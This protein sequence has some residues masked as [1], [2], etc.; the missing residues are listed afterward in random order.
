MSELDTALE[1]LRDELTA[2]IPLPDVEHVTG[3]A[4]TRRRLQ[5][6]AIATVIMVAAAVP[7]LRALPGSPVATPPVQPRTGYVM[8]FAD[9]DHGFAIGRRCEKT[10]EGCSFSFYRTTDGGR[11]WQTMT[12]PAPLSPD[13]GYFS[14][15][16]YVVG[17]YEVAINRLSGTPDDWVDR[18]HTTDGGRSW[19]EVKPPWVGGTTAPLGPRSLLGG[20]CIQISAAGMCAGLGMIEPGTAMSTGIPTQLPLGSLSQNGPVATKDGRWWA[21]SR[22]DA[23]GR[24]TMSVSADGGRSWSTSDLNLND[25][26]GSGGWAVVERNGVM[27]ATASSGSGLLGVWRSTDDGQSWTRT[28]TAGGRQWIPDLVGTPITASDGSLILSDGVTTYVSTDQ[29]RTFE[30]TG[31]KVAGTVRWT[32][33]GYLRSDGNVYATSSDGNNFALSTDGLHWRAFTVR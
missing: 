8:D 24:W 30:Q 33:A 1:G 14:A 21:V 2:A 18:I 17:P 3:R 6:G 16:M 10:R 25:T 9:P 19:Q 32:R 20:T 26:L 28:W 15:D 12:L 27:Y 31:E 23:T 29:G 13:T 11:D 7:T 22:N 4:R 5:V